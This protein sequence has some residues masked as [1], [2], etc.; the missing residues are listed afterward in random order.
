[1]TVSVRQT[2]GTNRA[3]ERPVSSLKNNYTQRKR[4]RLTKIMSSDKQQQEIDKEV[5]TYVCKRYRTS[6]DFSIENENEMIF[7]DFQ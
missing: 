4:K 1:M 2:I 7:N 5:R 3:C 6:N